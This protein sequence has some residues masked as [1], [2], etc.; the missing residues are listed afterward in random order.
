MICEY[1]GAEFEETLK[2]CENCGREFENKTIKE[3]D[4]NGKN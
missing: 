1:C 4:L 2:Y 3:E